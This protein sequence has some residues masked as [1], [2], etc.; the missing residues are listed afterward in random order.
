MAIAHLQ[1]GLNKC[2]D[3]LEHWLD[4]E[5]DQLGLWAPV[6][7]GLGIALWF[8][9]ESRGAWLAVI[10]AGLALALAAAAC[11]TGRRS[12][13]AVLWAGL[14]IA[15][16][17]ATI[18]IRSAQVATVRI[19]RP[20]VV[21]FAARI[22]A[23]DALCGRDGSRLVVA[24]AEGQGLP[25]RLRISVDSD[26]LPPNLTESEL[27]AI[28]ARLVPPADPAVPG[29][30]DFARAAWFLQIG[31]TGKALDP[32]RRLESP[33]PGR[34]SLRERMTRHIHERLP[35][36]A[37]GI[38]AAFATGDRGGISREDEEAMRSSG[39]THLL[40][41][42]GL[43]ITAVVAA[44]MFLTLK[45]LALSPWLALRLPLVLVSAAMGALAGIGYTL[46]TGAEV[47]TIRSCIAA[48]LVLAGLALGR[49]A[50]TLRLV[51]TGAFAV[52]LIWPESLVGASFQL[53]FAAITAI[54]ALHEHPRIRA[55]TM[56]RAE[57]VFARLIRAVGSLLLT[58]LVVELALAPIALFH[59]HKSGLY[60]ALANIVA[61]PLTTFVI[62]P[63]EAAALFLDGAGLGAPFWWAT[64]RALDILLW[65][66]RTVA[67]FPGAVAT[68]PAISTGEFSA[69][70]FGG[71][72]ILLWRAGLRWLGLVPLVCGALL[73]ALR[74]PPDL[75]V[76]GD[77]RHLAIRSDAGHVALLRP[78]TGDYMRDVLA[79][80]SGELDPLAELDDMSGAR[81]S[82]DI[83]LVA[84][85]R[86]GRPWQI[87]A[88]R[89]SYL[90]SRP[91]LGQLCRA[92]DLVISDRL[93]PQ[94]CTPRWLKLDRRLLRQTGGLAISL[95]TH[96]IEQV[97]TP[98]DDHP[99][100]KSANPI[101]NG[102]TVRPKAPAREPGSAHNVAADKPG[103]PDQAGSS[104]PP[105]GNI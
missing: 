18:W 5:R 77:G 27:I 21:R 42:S 56:R 68:L 69:I 7:F 85:I 1:R 104:S 66:A 41:I 13:T 71:L 82:R 105:S 30:Y 47:P 4:R 88:T 90:L 67:A 58:G 51:A 17:C 44:A 87:A 81:C 31:G 6:L 11:D 91:A 16:G 84:L 86:G 73:S 80:R 50:M 40:S 22:V 52:L 75:L 101:S 61:I 15:L 78:R 8:V 74:P 76:S 65:L 102:A 99:W 49:D 92:V 83:C 10:V 36:S 48:L 59:F 54:V 35:G 37:G 79:S 103:L 64:G 3:V 100:R 53:S 57:G 38:A 96:Q 24:P 9:A 98:G 33:A 97:L 29:A 34:I 89:S 26:K 93:L 14:F 62:M 20:V 19:D 23:I 45:L 46:L 25:E 70:L 2:L 55:L 94:N 43:H 60:G 32:L 95:S 39:L 28:R 63:L 72:W 12:V